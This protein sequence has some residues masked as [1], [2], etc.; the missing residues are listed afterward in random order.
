MPGDA[1][2][3]GAGNLGWHWA[4]VVEMQDEQSGA[5]QQPRFGS[6]WAAPGDSHGQEAAASDAPADDQV[7][8]GESDELLNAIGESQAEEDVVENEEEAQEEAEE[9]SAEESK[10]EKNPNNGCCSERDFAVPGAR[11]LKVIVA[12][13]RAVHG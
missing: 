12:F 13:V 2:S 8:D 6:P 4:K 11:V 9:E 5:N 1:R 3:T 7:S 10:R